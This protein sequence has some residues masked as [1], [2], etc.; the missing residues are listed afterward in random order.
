M[1][2]DNHYESYSNSN[3]VIELGTDCLK[4]KDLF[5]LLKGNVDWKY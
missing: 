2:A 5:K 4:R 3:S 1:C